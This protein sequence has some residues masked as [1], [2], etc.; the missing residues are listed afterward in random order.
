MKEKYNISDII[1]KYVQGECN[2]EEL[3]QAMLL[4]EEPYHNLGI[5]P[6][7]HKIWSSDEIHTE[8]KVPHNDLNEM[9]GHIHHQINLKRK[10]KKNPVLRQFLGTKF[11]DQNHC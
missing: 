8:I 4:F 7:L 6:E 10:K 9:L 11:Y 1:R 2:K 5:R 3:E